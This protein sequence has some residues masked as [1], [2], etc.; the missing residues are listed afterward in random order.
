MFGDWEWNSRRTDEQEG[1]FGEFLSGIN[2]ESNFL[3]IEIGE[4]QVSIE[5]LQNYC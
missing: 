4:I 3:V 1:N 5:L 2:R